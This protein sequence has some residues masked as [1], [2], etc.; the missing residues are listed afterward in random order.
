MSR[1]ATPRRPCP[2]D[3]KFHQGRPQPP[4][5]TRGQA[6]RDCNL[7]ATHKV[8]WPWHWLTL[9]DGFDN[10]RR[11]VWTRTTLRVCEGHARSIQTYQRSIGNDVK[12][13]RF[14]RV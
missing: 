12:V 2:F 4:W 13:Y 1:R 10:P 8:R 14:R 6:W 11:D 9:G 5:R 3:S 7:P